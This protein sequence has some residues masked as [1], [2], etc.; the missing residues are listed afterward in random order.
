MRFIVGLLICLAP[1]SLVADVLILRNG[2]QVEGDL[3]AVRSGV[4]EFQERRGFNG[5]RTLRVN[6]NEVVRIEL[7]DFDNGGGNVGNPRSPG[8]SRLPDGGRSSGMRERLVVVSANID[9]T[10]TGIDVRA[11]DVLVVRADGTVRLSGNATDSAGPDGANRRAD[12][13]PLP[14]HPSGA[15]IARVGN[16]VPIFVGDGRAMNR[17]TT[18]GRLYLGVNDDHSADNSGQFR[19]SVTVRQE[20]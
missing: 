15:L 17:L 12:N 6:R 19:A 20:R 14:N 1:A 8:Y 2:Q 10:D 16:A 18:G 9:W 5:G 7:D 11:G 4:I 3:I 13:S